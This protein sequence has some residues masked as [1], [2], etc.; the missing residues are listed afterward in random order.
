MV[1]GMVGFEVVG[2]GGVAVKGEEEREEKE[3]VERGGGPGHFVEMVIII[4]KFFWAINM[5]S[6]E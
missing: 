2:V 1:L 3:Q 5:G 6:R 4:W